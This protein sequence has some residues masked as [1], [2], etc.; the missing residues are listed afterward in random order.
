MVTPH[1]ARGANLSHE[2]SQQV[3]PHQNDLQDRRK[4]SCQDGIKGSILTTKQHTNSKKVGLN[5]KTMIAAMTAGVAMMLTGCGG[6]EVTATP[7]TS[8]STQSSAPT[9]TTSTTTVTKSAEPE[10]DCDDPSLSQ[11]EWM[12][13]CSDVQPPAGETDP[14]PVETSEPVY[15]DSPTNPVTIAEKIDGC[16]TGG[17]TEG[18]V[19]VMDYRYVTCSMPDGS[20]VT[21]TTY[22]GDPKVLEPGHIEIGSDG[23]IA[24]VGSDWTLIAGLPTDERTVSAEQ[25]AK[26]TGGEVVE[27]TY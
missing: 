21:I 17:S 19:D 10:V 24:V 14:S 12:K 22:P 2:E 23:T 25:Y 13:N 3:Q 5:M 27:P 9:E 26:W 8:S 6:G 7:N 15:E 1:K 16:D 18:E 4:G 20:E 11:S